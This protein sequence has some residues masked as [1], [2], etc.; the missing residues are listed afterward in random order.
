MIQVKGI[1]HISATV[2]DGQQDIDFYDGLLAM[3]LVKKT[4]NYDNENIY[5][6]YY[7]NHIATKG[8]MTTFPM[9][10]AIEG[11]IGG[12]QVSRS[13]FAIP[14]G[15]LPYW[16][17][18]LDKHNI[19]SQAITL[20]GKNRLN[21]MDN[22][23]LALQFVEVDQQSIAP[24]IN[25]SISQKEAFVGLDG[26]I[27][28]STKPAETLKVLTEILGYQSTKEEGNL[29][30][31]K[32][33][34]QLGGSLILNKQAFPKGRL[35]IGTVHHV[36]LEVGDQDLGLLRQKL[37]EE[38][39]NPTEII[40]RFY[41]KSLYFK[42]PGGIIIELATKGG[43]MTLDESIETLGTQFIIPH[44]FLN[45]KDTILERINP[46]GPSNLARLQIDE[47][48]DKMKIK[49]DAN[50]LLLKSELKS[51]S[52]LEKET[53]IKLRQILYDI[54]RKN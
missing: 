3:R 4:L 23:G 41:F 46:L 24:H 27:L 49:M 16:Q 2:G 33:H 45:K 18:R 7:G 44:H 9:E 51:L 21:F 34:D 15:S 13:I 37:I 22:D 30:L 35:G 54:T 25:E 8:L 17:A 20:F 26:V 50:T 19:K 11:L 5:H 36:A 39:L 52:D 47:K 42:E 14:K 6:L 48:T 43:G 38:G 53:Y 28:T 29:Q 40:N 1:H 12:G 10:N 32:V 31:L